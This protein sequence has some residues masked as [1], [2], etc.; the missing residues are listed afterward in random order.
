MSKINFKLEIFEG[1]LDVLLKLISKHKL[2]IY[3]IEISILLEQYL[4][5]ISNMKMA[6]LEISTEFLEMASH[7]VYIKTVSL[8]PKH[9]E[10]KELKKELEERLLEYKVYKEIAS[11]LNK[12]YVGSDIF[13]RKP[14]KINVD[15]KYIIIHNSDILLKAYLQ[16]FN[17]NTPNLP[18]Q[19]IF[20]KIVTRRIVSVTSR[21]VFVL[22]KL[23]K[24]DKVHYDE[25][26]YNPNKSELVATFLAMLEL[27]KSRRIYL[28]DEDNFVYFNREF[29][30][31][32]LKQEYIDN[33]Y[34]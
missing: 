19:S 15:K 26:F 16:N 33:Q 6:D 11:S 10:S 13:V 1:P 5:Y 17:K 4:D 12:R 7:L 8:L 18:K 24:N 28:C 23:Y 9:K 29:V 27:L 34:N 30:K 2:N 22:E 14:Q 3:D 31:E 32:D 25:F 20:S 21:I